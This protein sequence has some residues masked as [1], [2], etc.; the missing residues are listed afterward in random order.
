MVLPK[1]ARIFNVLYPL[2]FDHGYGQDICH[3]KIKKKNNIDTFEIWPTPIFLC[4]QIFELF[5]IFRKISA[6]FWFD[7]FLD[8]FL[9]RPTFVSHT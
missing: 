4:W 5:F 7:K 3:V 9:D 6:I 8:I 1:F 2:P